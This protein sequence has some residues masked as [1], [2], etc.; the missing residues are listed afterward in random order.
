MQIKRN[1]IYAFPHQLI[2]WSLHT[3]TRQKA[4]DSYQ[5]AHSPSRTHFH[6]DQIFVDQLIPNH[7]YG[8]N[9]GYTRPR[10]SHYS[11]IFCSSFQ[12]PSTLDN[13]IIDECDAG[14]ILG[15]FKAPPLP[16]FCCPV[17]VWSPSVLVVGVQFIT[18]LHLMVPVLIAQLTPIL[19]HFLTALLMKH[20]VIVSALGRDTLM[21]KMDF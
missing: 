13:N 12:H 9:T 6:P 7:Q 21:G 8:C 15:P 19:M 14:H 3:S 1:F 16:N 4:S 17:R 18:C 5:I 11:S 10:F 20:F 2:I